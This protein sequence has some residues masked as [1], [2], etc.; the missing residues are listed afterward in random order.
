MSDSAEE[1][2]ESR[3]WASSSRFKGQEIWAPTWHLMLFFP[4]KA[5]Q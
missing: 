3:E 1:G 2:W 5:D 4:L